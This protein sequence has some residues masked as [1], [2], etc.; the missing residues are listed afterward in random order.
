MT[1]QINAYI[2]FNGK[3][4]EAMTFY[5]QCLGGS[6]SLTSVGESPM[7][8]QISMPKD[9]IMH[10]VLLREGVVMLMASDMSG[11][12]IVHGNNINLMLNCSSEEEINSFYSKLSEG[13]QVTH[14]VKEESW[15]AL[16][17]HFTDKFGINWMLNF[18]K[19][20]AM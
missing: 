12:Q 9:K 7:A 20:A 6:L 18:Q 15:G 10:A 2:G 1:A 3:C 8:D 5:Q 19:N 11:Q 14:P 17:G 4:K 13:G 16:F